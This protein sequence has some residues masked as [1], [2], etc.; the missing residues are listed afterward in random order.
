MS[1]VIVLQRDHHTFVA[2]LGSPGGTAILAYNAKALVGLLMWNMP[3]QAAFDLPN[4]I[5]RGDDVF[6]EARRSARR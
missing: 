5:A 4:V 1:P 2:A 3:L 6:G